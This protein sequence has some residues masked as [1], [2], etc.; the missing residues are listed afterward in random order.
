MEHADHLK[1]SKKAFDPESYQGTKEQLTD[2]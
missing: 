1:T 2:A